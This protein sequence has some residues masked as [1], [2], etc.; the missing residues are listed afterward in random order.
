[1]CFC[2]ESSMPLPCVRQ[3]DNNMYVWQV[4]ATLIYMYIHHG[5]WCLQFK[6]YLQET[7]LELIR[8]EVMHVGTFVK[9]QFIILNNVVWKGPHITPYM[10]L[11]KRTN[12]KYTQQRVYTAAHYNCFNIWLHCSVELASPQSRLIALGFKITFIIKFCRNYWRY[13]VHSL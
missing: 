3:K 10:T 6:L 2:V 7:L 1:M 9:L 12:Y 11:K 13:T 8:I 5:H 4:Y